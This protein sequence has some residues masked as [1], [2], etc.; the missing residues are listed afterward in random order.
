MT[1]H[2]ILIWRRMTRLLGAALA[3]GL[4]GLL[5]IAIAYYTR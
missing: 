5:A 1:R 3:S 2:E 4:V